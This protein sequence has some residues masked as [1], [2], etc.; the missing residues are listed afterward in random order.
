M[1]MK[2]LFAAA[3]FGLT[4]A[5]SASALTIDTSDQWDG[6][7]NDGW[8]ASAQTLTV[9]ALASTLLNISFYFDE[10]AAG[11][12]FTFTIS[13]SQVGGTTFFTSDFSV[14][15]GVNSFMTN[16]DLSGEDTI[17]AIF[18][19][20]G[21]SGASAHYTEDDVYAGGNS[22]FDFNG[23]DNWRDFAAFDHRF[24]AVFDGE[25]AAVPLPAGGLLLLAGM[26]GIAS[27]RRRKKLA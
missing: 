13:D 17:Y 11:E 9:D 12:D 1:N 16:V 8:M 26:G 14:Q 21:Y 10:E 2:S 22:S 18:D 7:V 20:N 27:L 24:T 25:V 15:A 3:A 4:T 6:T 23:D 5:T 19:Y